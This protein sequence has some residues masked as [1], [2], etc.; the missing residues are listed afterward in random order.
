MGILF[1]V[2]FADR[3]KYYADSSYKDVCVPVTTLISKEYAQERYQLINMNKAATYDPPGNIT[4]IDGKTKE[5]FILDKHEEG[6]TI[7]LTVADGDG[8]MVSWIQSNY[9]GFGSGLVSPKLGFAFQDRGA[10]FSLNNGTNNCYNTGKRPFHTIMPGFLSKKNLETNEWDPYM[11]F[12]VMGGYV[13]PQGHVQ[14]VSNIV[15]FGMNVQEAG[16]AARWC[17][18]G[19]QQP[20]GE[21]MNPNGGTVLLESGICITVANELIDRGHV[22][23]YEPNGGGYQGIFRNH[24]TGVLFGGTE[25]RKDGIALGY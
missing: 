2:A 20:T 14:I 23:K 1:D 11:S 4:C 13:Q 21:P 16:D 19:S 25:M 15:D 22:V 18:S 17:H 12:G 9:N 5:E 24:T 8:M 10:L 7:Y 6:D 3:A